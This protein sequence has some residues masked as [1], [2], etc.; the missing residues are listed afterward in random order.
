MTALDHAADMGR[1]LDLLREQEPADEGDPGFRVEEL[2]RAAGLATSTMHQRVTKLYDAGY[3]I[4]G[5]RPHTGRDGRQMRVSVYRLD[6]SKLPPSA[7]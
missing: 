6:E 1:I 3:L 7:T 2:A 4:R 5:T